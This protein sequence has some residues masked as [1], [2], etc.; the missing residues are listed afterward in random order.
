MFCT[1]R[2]LLRITLIATYKMAAVLPA[3]LKR[4]DKGRFCRAKA[5]IRNKNAANRLIAPWSALKK[6]ENEKSVRDLEVCSGFPLRGRRVV[7]L[8]VLAEALDG[9]CE[10]CG[11]ALRLSDCIKE[12]V[13]G[14]GSLL[15]I[16]CSNSECGETNICRTNK[17]HRSTGTTRGRPIFDVNT[18]LAAGLCTFNVAKNIVFHN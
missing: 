12:T 5:F 6:Q 7:E 1:A 4:T 16:C 13:S 18:K 15:Y 3:G 8:N 10:A 9:G 2:P 17:T 14:L 11:V